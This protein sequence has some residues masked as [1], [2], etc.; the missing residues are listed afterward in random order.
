MTARLLGRSTA[1]SIEGQDTHGEEREDGDGD[2]D[3]EGAAASASRRSFVRLLP[4]PPAAQ[5]DTAAAE[6]AAAAAAAGGEPV[7]ATAQTQ[8]QA[9][10]GEAAGVQARPL[11]PEL[12]LKC[13]ARAINSNATSKVGGRRR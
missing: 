3:G 10:T 6:A 5:V 11:T 12:G 13:R 4:D 8:A 1:P 7:A 9:P 2:E